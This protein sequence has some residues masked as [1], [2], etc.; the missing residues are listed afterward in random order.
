MAVSSASNR[1]ATKNRPALLEFYDASEI[2]AS[3]AHLGP[4]LLA[5]GFS[6]AQAGRYEMSIIFNFHRANLITFADFQYNR[7]SEYMVNYALPLANAV[8]SRL[9]GSRVSAPEKTGL[10]D[11]TACELIIVGFG[12]AGKRIAEAL[13][14]KQMQPRIIELNP[15]SAKKAQKMGLPVYLGDA[16]DSEVL[17]HAV[18]EKSA[19]VVVTVP[20]PHA[21]RD[22][23]KNIRLTAPG[24]AVIARGRYHIA[25]KQLEAVG[26]SAVIDE[27]NVVGVRMAQNVLDFLFTAIPF[28]M[29][30]GLAG[31]NPIF[32]T[33]A[34][35]SAS[36]TLADRPLHHKE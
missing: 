8:F 34:S 29:A 15:K 7:L 4:A 28:S 14:E 19:A 33:I 6:E 24:A 1:R 35:I 26:A 21:C 17:L 36:M 22:I 30:C 11:S 31:N 3:Q 27:E 23:I 20:D 25:I 13:L 32:R 2:S 16:T 12:P 18:I 5:S 9:L 10:Q